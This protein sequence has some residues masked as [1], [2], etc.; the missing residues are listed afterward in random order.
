MLYLASVTSIVVL[1]IAMAALFV[2]LNCGVQAFD[3]IAFYQQGLCELPQSPYQLF[4]RIVVNGG[5]A[6]VVIVT[7]GNLW[8]LMANRARK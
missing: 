2:A 3:R 4:S 7:L 6:G 8:T 5:I 1:G